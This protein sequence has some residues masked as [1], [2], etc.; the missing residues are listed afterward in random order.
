MS[1]KQDQ[2]HIV[3]QLDAHS[4]EFTID[5]DKEPYFRSAARLL[6]ER[7]KRYQRKYRSASVEQLWM[8]VALDVGVNLENLRQQKLSQPAEQTINQLNKLVTDKLNQPN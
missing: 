6:N 7:Y 4:V 2:Q 8:Y 1:D 5:R 3:L